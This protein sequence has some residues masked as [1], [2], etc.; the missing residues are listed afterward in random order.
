MFYCREGLT[1]HIHSISISISLKI[2]GFVSIL[3]LQKRV[4]YCSQVT[5]GEWSLKCNKISRL[6]NKMGWNQE[7]L[8]VRETANFIPPK[9]IGFCK[10]KIE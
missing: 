9:L 5:R 3:I 4:T 8:E 6:V 1:S 10:V 2:F 7:N